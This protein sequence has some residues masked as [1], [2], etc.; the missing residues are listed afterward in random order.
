MTLEFDSRGLLRP[1]IHEAGLDELEIHFGRFQRS[2][3]R[4]S[5]FAK[6]RDY[7]AE[8]KSAGWDCEIVIDGS[9]VMPMV[10]EPDDIDLILVLPDGW[11]LEADLRPFEYNLV[12]KR[13][14]AKAYEV[15]LAVVLAGSDERRQW[16]G[17]FS[18]VNEKWCQAFGWPIGSTKGIVR[19]LQ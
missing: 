17:F 11:D 5:L 18:R 12:S 9:F 1:G 6:L 7:L 2:S 3:R 10:D 13:R 4:A 8:L 19:L 16:V 15:G 14:V